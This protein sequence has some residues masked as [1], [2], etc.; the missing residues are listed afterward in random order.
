MF[1]NVISFKPSELR[2][3]CLISLLELHQCNLPGN[4]SPRKFQSG[5]Y[6]LN[7]ITLSFL[8]CQKYL[9]NLCY[10]AQYNELAQFCSAAKKE[11]HTFNLKLEKWEVSR[12]YHVQLE[13]H[14]LV[15]GVQKNGQTVIYPVFS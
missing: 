3:Q 5:E 1:M 2:I 13:M 14:N 8:E 15:A 12:I 9:L 6:I 7:L 11:L 10:H 4:T